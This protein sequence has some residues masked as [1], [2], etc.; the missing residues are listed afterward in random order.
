MFN[1]SGK[2]Q[3]SDTLLNTDP[4]VWRRDLSNEIGSLAQGIGNVIGN[5]VLDFVQRHTIPND[6][7][8]IR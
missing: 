3:T 2:R 4:V 1:P 7:S 8:G 5:G 6:K